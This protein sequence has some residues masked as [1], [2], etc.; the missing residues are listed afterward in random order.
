LPTNGD[1]EQMNLNQKLEEIRN[2]LKN[3]IYK[4]YKLQEGA[5]KMGCASTDKKLLSNLNNVIKESN[6][7]IDELNQ[8]LLDLNSY[9]VISQSESSVV[10]ESI[11][12]DDSPERNSYSNGSSGRPSAE[13]TYNVNNSYTNS[14]HVNNNYNNNG[15]N[16]S[17]TNNNDVNSENNHNNNTNGNQ[18]HADPR[19]TLHE[20]RIKALNRQLEI[21]MK[22][23]VGAE[24][25]IQSFSQGPKKDK[26]LCD[27]AQAMLKDAKLKIEYIKMQ[28]N[29]VNNQ[30]NESMSSTMYG[31]HRN[32]NEENLSNKL[33]VL[34]PVEIR[35]EELRHRLHIES[36]VCEGAKNAVNI[37]QLQKHDKK[38]LQQVIFFE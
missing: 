14:N 2:F 30:Y 35:I 31:H 12:N 36:A 23:K 24:N 8:E 26:K 29:K 25:M 20:Q 3:E 22:I 10:L 11:N 5:E 19:V 38:A 1:G 33:E 16:G 21:E 9:I 27:D 17:K 15:T 37:L 32:I 34:M 7:K 13:G 28:L 4:Q 6:N 18:H